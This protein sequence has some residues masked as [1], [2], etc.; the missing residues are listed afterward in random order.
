[1][2]ILWLNLPPRLWGSIVRLNERD[3]DLGIVTPNGLACSGSRFAIPQEIECCGY[4][5]RGLNL[6]ARASLRHIPNRARDKDAFREGFSR[7]SINAFAV[8]A[9][10]YPRVILL[11]IGNKSEMRG[12]VAG[13]NCSV[14]FYYPLQ[15]LGRL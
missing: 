13:V 10:V 12:W 8:E 15:K 6:Q 14:D 9:A 2:A 1:M 3:A 7:T 11:C 4:A 5:T